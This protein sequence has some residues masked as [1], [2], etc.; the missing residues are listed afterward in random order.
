MR[1]LVSLFTFA[2]L[3]LFSHAQDFVLVSVGESYGLQSY[4]SLDND[5]EN[6][7]DNNAWD[8]AF[9]FHDGSILINESSKTTFLEPARELRCYE[10]PSNNF[11]ETFTSD[12]IGERLW[13]VEDDW[14]KGALNTSRDSNDPDDLGWGRRNN[15]GTI[16][17]E[18]VFALRLKSGSWIKLMVESANASEYKIKTAGLDGS[19]PRIFSIPVRGDAPGVF[20]YYSLESN[21]VV[22]SVPDSW[23][24]VFKRYVTPID[25]NLGGFLDYTVTGVLTFPGTQVA[26]AVGVVP[27][28]V[29]LSTYRD[30]FS[31]HADAIGYEW[32]DFDFENS[33][34]WT[35]YED[36]AYFIK[37]VSGDIWKIVFIDFEGTSTGNAVFQKYYLGVSSVKDKDNNSL[38]MKV[39]PNPVNSNSQ[40]V[41]DGIKSGQNIR[42]QIFDTQGQLVWQANSNVTNGLN[43]LHLR[44]LRMPGGTY[45]LRVKTNEQIITQTI[46]VAP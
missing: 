37:T 24:M 23:D 5:A 6:Q 2:F 40:V 28:D 36:Q 12:D 15:D 38:F 27:E 1:S 32:K 13:N 19:N 20:S 26:K 42:L 3:S 10:A 29:A 30:S 46:F 39:Y 33:N 9:H 34:E 8:L 17:G 43:V 22:N 7:V 44:D 41:L 16:S 4:Y 18:K 11:D 35:V 14:S 31:Q 25:D 45:H 21:S